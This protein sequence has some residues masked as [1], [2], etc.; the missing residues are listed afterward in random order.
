VNQGLPDANGSRPHGGSGIAA[1][2]VQ[3]GENLVPFL[4][5]QNLAQRRTGFLSD[6]LIFLLLV[7]LLFGLDARVV[8]EQV[9]HHLY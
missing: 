7:L 6:L 3:R 5:S 9:T 2:D 1:A 4:F 8:E